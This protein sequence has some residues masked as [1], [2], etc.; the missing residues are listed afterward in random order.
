MGI[1]RDHA[2]NDSNE[3]ISY[4][5]DESHSESE[6]YSFSW[7][8]IK[9]KRL[10]YFKIKPSIILNKSVFFHFLLSC[11]EHT[12]TKLYEVEMLR[13]VEIR[14]DV[15]LIRELEFQL[16]CFFGN[17]LGNTIFPPKKLNSRIGTPLHRK[18]FCNEISAILIIFGVIL[19]LLW[20]PICG[21]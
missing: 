8:L 3:M 1:Q 21:R 5:D 10:I 2:L 18:L 11:L 20:V 14:P 9:Y 19:H 16:W 13:Q 4:S 17:L 7:W 12:Y 15:E 6:E